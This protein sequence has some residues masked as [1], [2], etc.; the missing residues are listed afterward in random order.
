MP[1]RPAFLLDIQ[2]TFLNAG[3]LNA[4]PILPHQYMLR[5]TSVAVSPPAHLL[6]SLC[7]RSWPAGLRLCCSSRTSPSTTRG[8]CWSATAS[9]TWS[10]TTTYR[11]VGRRQGKDLCGFD[12]QQVDRG[13]VRREVGGGPKPVDA[14]L[15]ASAATCHPSPSPMTAQRPWLSM[16]RALLCCCTLPRT[17]AHEQRDV[18]MHVAA[19]V[20]SPP[21]CPPA[22]LPACRQTQIPSHSTH[23]RALPPPRLL[24]CTAPCG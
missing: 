2:L 12:I 15:R 20:F 4:R 1:K 8:R 6:R 21:P 3:A 24:G 9:T 11:C 17:M 7:L 13:S 18:F 22:N 23:P 10:S 14:L 5:L 16:C 19:K